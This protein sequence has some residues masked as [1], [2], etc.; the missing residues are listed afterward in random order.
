MG[1]AGRCSVLWADCPAP[2]STAFGHRP[3]K[4][5]PCDFRLNGCSWTGGISLNFWKFP[6]R[7]VVII[8][9]VKFD[10]GLWWLTSFSTR[11]PSSKS[12]RVPAR[13]AGCLRRPVCGERQIY[14]LGNFDVARSI[15]WSQAIVRPAKQCARP[16]ERL[17]PSAIVHEATEGEPPVHRAAE[18]K[19]TMG[20]PT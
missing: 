8:L 10:W 19:R 12:V 18:R 5:E 16:P 14:N 2:R 20:I 6:W 4:N 11:V 13:R 3:R 9:G 7:F 17:F 1:A 15:S